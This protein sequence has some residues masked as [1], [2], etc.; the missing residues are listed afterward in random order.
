M[1]QSKFTSLSL[2]VMVIIIGSACSS[3]K[4]AYE[5]GNYYDAVITSVNRLRRNT[6][7][8]KSSETLRS[9]YP[10]AV[11]YYDD[12]ANAAIASNGPG[13]WQEVVQ[14][15]STLQSMY[16]EIQRSP[17]AL[18]V[19]PNPISYQ[20]K[21]ADARQKAADESYN[22]GIMALGIGDR[23]NA[24]IAYYHFIKANEY[25]PGYR[26]VAKMIADARWAATVKVAVE[27]IPVAS[28]NYSVNAQYFDNKLNEYLQSN[29]SNE[30]LRF[31]K[32]EDARSQKINLDHIVQLNFDEFSIGQVYV[33]EKESQVERD[34]V[35][36]AYAYTDVKGSLLQ[37]KVE[38]PVIV[39]PVAVVVPSGSGDNTSVKVDEKKVTDTKSS[40]GGAVKVEE[41]KPVVEVKPVTEVKPVV[42]ATTPAVVTNPVAETKPAEVK[43]ADQPAGTRVTSSDEQKDKKDKEEQVTLCHQPPGKPSE[44]KILTLPKS[45]VQAHLDHGDVLG[46]CKDDGKKE[47]KKNDKG[48]DKGNGSNEGSQDMAGLVS[49]NQLK[50][51]MIASASSDNRWYLYHEINAPADT[52]RIFGKV[53]ATVHHY[54]KTITSRGVLNFR[55]IDA[56]TRAVISEERMPSESVW[57]SEWLTY[58]GDSRALSPEQENLARQK[59]TQP[60]SSQ[61]LFAEFTRPLLDQITSKITQFYRNY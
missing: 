33:N 4:S 56:K 60:P 7:S 23:A 13:R 25:S 54:K 26:D 18:K 9:A 49:F 6:D 61:D 50:P 2:F 32:L 58:N 17:G 55:I 39:P 51:I 40:D 12:R 20:A 3:G 44:R 53:K 16:D 24:K 31:Y 28:R 27:P 38:A 22:A 1:N 45:A 52:T 42:V 19:I 14:H 29:Q 10:M 15:Y 21:L 41:A 46:E 30:F 47:D 11:K 48:N 34:S 43:T 8:K 36:V 35:V 59:E 37:T 57:I 5:Q